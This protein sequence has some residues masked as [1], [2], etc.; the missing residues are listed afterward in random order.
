MKRTIESIQPKEVVHCKTEAEAV[1]FCKMMD[2]AGLRWLDGVSF[3]ADS[4]WR[5]Y[6]QGTC[7]KPDDPSV[8]FHG[9]AVGFGYTIT[10]ATDFIPDATEQNFPF[11]IISDETIAQAAALA[12]QVNHPAHYNTGKIEVGEFIQDQDLDFYAGNAVKYICRAGKKPDNSE[13]QDLNKA[14]Q[15]LQ[16]RVEY[17]E[18]NKTTGK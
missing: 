4:F 9:T 3:T 13:I 15:C 12:E 17:L 6:E 7:Y 18:R 1:A 8:L 16:N 10:P 2:E 5:H 11:Q 14:I